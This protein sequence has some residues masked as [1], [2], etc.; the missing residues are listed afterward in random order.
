MREDI[1][2]YYEL[3][4]KVVF[5][6]Y[7]K[8]A[9]EKFDAKPDVFPYHRI[10]FGMGMSFKYNMNG[11]ACNVHFQPFENGVAVDIHYTIAQ[12]WGARYK[13][14]EADFQDAVT[15]ILG[16]QGQERKLSPEFFENPIPY[17]PKAQV[18]QPVESQPVTPPPQPQTAVRP[19]FCSSCGSPLQPQANFCGS[20]GNKIN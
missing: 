14:H 1:Y 11:G 2:R 5:D 12:L 20:C 13:K 6:A 7:V 17:E 9:A 19:K 18:Q 15:A 8:A 16:V 10:A 3:D 4:Q